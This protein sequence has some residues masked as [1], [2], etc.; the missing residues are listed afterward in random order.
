MNYTVKFVDSDTF[1]KLPYNKVGTSVGVADRNRGIAYV[2]DTG[3]PMD[4]FTAHHE[5]EHLKGDDLHELESPGEDGVYYKNFGESVG[6]FFQASIPGTK[7]FKKWAIAPLAGAAGTAVG[8]PVAGAA[9]YQGVNSFNSPKQT[10][11]SF[12]SPTMDSF[13][14]A[15]SQIQS[16]Q[17]PA[18]SPVGGSSGGDAGDGLGAGTID[19]VRQLLAKQNQSG[20]YAG[21]DPGGL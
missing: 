10:D 9:A 5:L 8:G 13:N 2:R 6:Q 21:R 18:T 11:S 17:A 14:P 4:I 15:T 20:F 1:D 16:P 19:K 7:A 3:N 12:Q